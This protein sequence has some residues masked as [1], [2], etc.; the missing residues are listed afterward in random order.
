MLCFEDLVSEVDS[1]TYTLTCTF[2]I[3]FF[4]S[5]YHKVFDQEKQRLDLAAHIPWLAWD[6]HPL[7]RSFDALNFVN[8]EE[9]GI[10]W[11]G[12]VATYSSLA[13]PEHLEA[14]KACHQRQAVFQGKIGRDW[15]VMGRKALDFAIRQSQL[16]KC[17]VKFLGV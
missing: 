3:S 5:V 13:P 11:R 15:P 16:C 10:I 12:L 17:H 6:D 2:F 8:M 9:Y 7:Q 14:A 1:V 4:L